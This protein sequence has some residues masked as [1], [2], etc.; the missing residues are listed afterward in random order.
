MCEH[1][2]DEEPWPDR[3]YRMVE[4]KPGVFKMQDVTHETDK[5]ESEA[6]A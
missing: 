3:V 2:T 4:V 6:T 1:M 5:P